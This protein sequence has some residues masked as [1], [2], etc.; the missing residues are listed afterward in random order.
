MA[1]ALQIRQEEVDQQELAQ[2]VG[3]HRDLVALGGALRL[4][5]PGLVDGRIDHQRIEGASQGGH[6]GFRPSPHT[7]QIGQI[8]SQMAELGRGD[9]QA[10]GGSCRPDRISVGGHHL[11]A[12]IG[13][14]LSRMEAD[15]RGGAGDQNRS[16]A[17]CFSHQTR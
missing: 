7:V 10:V 2:M 5:Q 8:K 13:Q 16:G 6:Q 17:N 4:L 1:G 3:G 9:S 15:S 14:G 12:P 11:P